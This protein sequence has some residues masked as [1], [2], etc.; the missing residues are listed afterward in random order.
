MKKVLL[1]ALFIC[2]GLTL[3][4]SPYIGVSQG[5]GATSVELG[6]MTSSFEENIFVGIP[7]LMA[8][9]SYNS[10]FYKTVVVGTD[11]IYRFRPI[12]PLVIGFGPTFRAAWETGNAFSLMAGVAYQLSLETPDVMDILYVEGAYIP[13]FMQYESGTVTNDF[14]DKAAKQIFRLGWRHAF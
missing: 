6:F 13:D 4:A 10:D 12:G 3:F 1:T 5:L 2:M 9:D 8:M 14:L 11:L 7:S